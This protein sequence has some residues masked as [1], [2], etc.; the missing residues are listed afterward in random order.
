VRAFLFFPLANRR[1]FCDSI[2]AVAQSQTQPVSRESVRVLAISVGVREAARQL[3]LNEN[4]VRQW[5]SRFNWFQQ[6]PQP[7]SKRPVTTVTSPGDA[8]LQHLNEHKNE[9]RISLARSVRRLAKRAEKAKLS[10]S[11]HVLNVA[12]TAGHTFEDWQP[13][14]IAGTNVMVNIALLGVEPGQ[15]IDSGT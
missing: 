7:P 3:G 15:I 8:L 2:S 9:T 4:T 14:Q 11:K 1:A 12:Q 13:K 5:S 10:D 6:P